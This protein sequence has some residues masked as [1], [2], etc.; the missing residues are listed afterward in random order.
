[1]H[2][3]A[4][5]HAQESGCTKLYV[6]RMKV[7]GRAGVGG[8][9]QIGKIALEVIRKNFNIHIDRRNNW[10][11]NISLDMYDVKKSDEPKKKGGQVSNERFRRVHRYIIGVLMNQYVSVSAYEYNIT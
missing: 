11:N 8:G 5:G 3:Y 1:M 2:T 7:A 4:C 10:K 9:G 6:L